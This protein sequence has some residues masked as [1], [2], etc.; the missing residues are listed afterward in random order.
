MRREQVIERPHLEREKR[1]AEEPDQWHLEDLQVLEERDRVNPAATRHGVERFP[2]HAGE[3]ARGHEPCDASPA[4]PGDVRKQRVRGVAPVQQRLGDEP[5]CTPG[6][7]VEIARESQH[8]RQQSPADP[9]RD[10]QMSRR[11][12][13]A[14]EPQIVPQDRKS[15]R[16]NSSH[17]QISYAVFCLKKK[18]NKN[19][20]HINSRKYERLFAL[21]PAKY[22]SRI[23]S[24]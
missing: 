16:L 5:H 24:D 15:T 1:E 18:K 22:Q 19:T 3:E 21:Q 10:L 9:A 17:S 7:R 11:E 4:A 13:E 14:A 20:S 23:C 8:G 6:E 12:G 2:H